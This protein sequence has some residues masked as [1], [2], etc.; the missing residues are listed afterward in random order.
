M[1]RTGAIFMSDPFID[2]L[3]AVVG[4]SG[5]P[6]DRLSEKRDDAQALAE[7]AAHAQARSLVFVSDT[8]V[9]KQRGD[10]LDAFFTLAEV[11][12]LGARD[13]QALLGQTPEGP[14]FATLLRPDVA[15]RVEPNGALVL[16]GR[17]DLALIDLRSLAAKA[18]LPRPTIAMM[19]QGKSLLFWHA[20]HR[21]CS[22]CGA[23]SAVASA[24]W[25]RECAACKAQHFPRTDP[26]VIMLTV[27]GDRCLLGRQA[28]FAPGMYSAL[29]GFLEPGECIEEAVRREIHEEAGVTC[30]AVRYVTS[31]PWPFGGSQ[32]MIACTAD[33]LGDALTLDTDEIEDAMWVTKEEAMAA[34]EG[35]SDRR[36]NAPPPFAIAH[37][38]LRHWVSQ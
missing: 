3:S 38:L 16:P 11:A 32:L 26:V 6:L 8:P 37:S 35:A 29:A 19:A 23:P 17:E 4:F 20:K 2:E 25:K 5:N 27:Q 1:H 36:F 30:G 7:L 10:A 18:L 15:R 34:L 31:Q 24:G 22:Q 12:A 13:E 14:I 21:F 33:A 9:L 28:R